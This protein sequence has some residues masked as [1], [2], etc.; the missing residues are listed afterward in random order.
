MTDT[1]AIRNTTQKGLENFKHHC[2]RV[3]GKSSR[4]V[5]SECVVEQAYNLLLHMAP[6]ILADPVL[7][8]RLRTRLRLLVKNTYRNR[9]R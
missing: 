1:F 9:E 5:R 7:C 6:V 8:S 4:S 3:I 2:C